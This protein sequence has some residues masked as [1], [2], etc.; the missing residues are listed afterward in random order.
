MQSYAGVWYLGEGDEEASDGGDDDDANQNEGDM[1]GPKL[2]L[3]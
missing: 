2:D 3:K 1:L